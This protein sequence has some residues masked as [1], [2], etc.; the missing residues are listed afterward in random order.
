MRPLIDYR[1]KWGVPVPKAVG[2]MKKFGYLLAVLLLTAGLTSCSIDSRDSGSRPA[3]TL[4]DQQPPEWTDDE[5]SVWKLMSELYPE[6]KVLD[7]EGKRALLRMPHDICLSYDEGYTRKEI[8]AV[9]SA[10]GSTNSAF[11]DDLMTLGVTY[12]CPEFFDLQMAD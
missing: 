8:A 3:T 11:N 9:M 2:E 7:L 12:F 4:A 6:V 1:L 5:T 10:S